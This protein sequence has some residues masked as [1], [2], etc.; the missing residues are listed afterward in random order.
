MPK[1]KLNDM[2]ERRL[3]LDAWK[4]IVDVQMHFND[5]LMR[6]RNLGITLI[7]AVFG[8][9]AFS[10]QYEL[11]LRT[12][13]GSIHLASAIILFGL[14]AWAGIGFMD[15][16]YNKLLAGAVAKSSALE[17]MYDENWLGMTHNITEA[18]RTV[19][20]KANL[21]MA[22]QQMTYFLY[23][24]IVVIGLLYV[25]VVAWWFQPSYTRAADKR[26]DQER[27]LEAPLVPRV[28]QVEQAPAATRPPSVPMPPPESRQPS[29]TP[30]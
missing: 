2:D 10:L 14:C 19:F 15:R 27:R 4:A 1:V 12:P 5:V 26:A 16:Y 21:M 23:F 6:V 17:D 22:R 11:F 24:P 25:C 13:W 7:L 30:K 8:A 3:L 18:S 29:G 20:G 9:A 28:P